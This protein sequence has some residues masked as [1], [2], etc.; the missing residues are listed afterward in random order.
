MVGLLTNSRARMVLIIIFGTSSIE[1]L[2]ALQVFEESEV[3]VDGIGQA[4][5]LL[6]DNTYSN[7]CISF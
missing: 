3:Y 1:V 7:A 4:C 6:R 5:F 2:R